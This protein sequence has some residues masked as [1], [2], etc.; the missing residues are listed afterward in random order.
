[1]IQ[2]F[3][4]FTNLHD[5]DRAEYELLTKEYP[6]ISD[7]SFST[8]MIWWNFSRDVKVSRLNGNLVI[9]YHQLGSRKYTGFSLV[10]TN[11][12][13]ESVRIVFEELARRN[14]SVRLVHVPDFTVEKIQNSQDF[15]IEEEDAYHEYIV[16]VSRLF[17]L[18]ETTSKHRTKINRF[19]REVEGKKLAVKSVDLHSSANQ[20]LLLTC[21]EKWW[22]EY[23]SLNDTR[24]DEKHA[25]RRSINESV[26]LNM[27]NLCVFIDGQIAGFILFQVSY[28]GQYLIGNHMKARKDIPRI[29]DYLD[30]CAARYAAGQG[31]PYLNIEMDLGIKGLRI[32]K[33]GLK[34][35]KLFK[36]YRITPKNISNSII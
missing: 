36:K 2:Q 8:L 31:I 33:Q 29:Y 1:M 27:R 25:I 34:P 28:D 16:P 3:P 4:K 6:P 32:H 14:R 12:V 9:F 17:P 22:D 10:G 11:K 30:F 35:E 7:L 18:E 13:D 23:G 19:M 26:S 21:M 20:E 5:S 24:G 15:I